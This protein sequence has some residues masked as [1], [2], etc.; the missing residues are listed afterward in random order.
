VNRGHPVGTSKV[1]RPNVHMSNFELI[2]EESVG[3]SSGAR[4]ANGGPGFLEGE[5]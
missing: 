4:R 3:R 2:G 5:A 1:G